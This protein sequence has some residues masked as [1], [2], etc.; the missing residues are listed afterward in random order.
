MNGRGGVAF[1]DYAEDE[2]S[3]DDES[4]FQAMVPAE[5]AEPFGRPGNV[6][7][8]RDV[9]FV[10]RPLRLP[11]WGLEAF[12]GQLRLKN[13]LLLHLEP[14]EDGVLLGSPDLRMWGSGGN[15]FEALNDFSETFVNV[16]RS[17]EATPPDQLTPDAVA[18][19]RLL[20]SLVAREAI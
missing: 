13:A 16:L 9:L 7:R 3:P 6:I 17:Y 5:D 10:Q 4:A 11:V 14:D 12:G 20:Q 8:L 19:L 15:M 1:A 18:Y 2:W